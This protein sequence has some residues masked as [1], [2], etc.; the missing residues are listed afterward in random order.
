MITLET[1]FGMLHL[2]DDHKVKTK[3]HGFVPASQLDNQIHIID[4]GTLPDDILSIVDDYKYDKV[5]SFE[6]SGFY[7]EDELVKV[8]DL[9]VDEDCSFRTNVCMVHNSAAGSLLSYALGITAIDP[10]PYGLMFSRYLNAGRAKL[11][12]IE[13]KGYPLKEWL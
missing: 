6:L 7:D 3:H 13:I 1:E 2:T 10:I 4:R 5:D 8:Y 9:M 11:P 12:V